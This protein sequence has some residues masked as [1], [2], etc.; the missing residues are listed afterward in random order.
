MTMR[1]CA[2]VCAGHG[3]LDIN[4]RKMA[5]RDGVNDPPFFAFN[6]DAACEILTETGSDVNSYKSAM[7]V[8]MPFFVY[9]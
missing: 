3:I 1:S 5:H 8:G 6:Q 9:E 4:A 2:L 7:Q